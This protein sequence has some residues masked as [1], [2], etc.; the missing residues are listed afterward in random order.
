MDVPG[1]EAA[2]LYQMFTRENIVAL[3]LQSMR[4]VAD[5]KFLIE[6]QLADGQVLEL[7]WRVD[8]ALDWVWLENDVFDEPRK[9]AVLYGFAMKN[10]S[11]SPSQR[12]KRT[13][14]P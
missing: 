13:Q 7:A 3:C 4:S 10:V 11:L 6:R 9:W 5:Y 14:M 2:Q 12:N 1:L 8:T